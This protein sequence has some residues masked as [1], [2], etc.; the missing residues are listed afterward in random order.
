MT[1]ATLNTWHDLFVD[2]NRRARHMTER[3][4]PNF[5]CQRKGHGSRELCV[6]AQKNCVAVVTS[7]HDGVHGLGY[8]WEDAQVKVGSA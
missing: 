5:M 4:M 8:E 7:H 1:H 2:V 3:Y 6:L